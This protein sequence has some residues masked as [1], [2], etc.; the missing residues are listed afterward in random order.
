MAQ[1]R[2]TQKKRYKIKY[3]NVA[4]LLAIFLILILLI[5]KGCSAIF[6]GREKDDDNPNRDNPI[7]SG[8]V[9]QPDPVIPDDLGNT[10]PTN[11]RYYHFT[12]VSKTASDLGVG[13]L[14]LVN[15]NIAFNGLVSEDDLVVIRE[16]KNNAYSVKDYSVLILPQ[17]MDA[18]N[19]MLLGFREAT[20]NDHIMV[21]SGYRTP[22]YQQ[23]LY[24]EDLANTGSDSSSLVAKPGYSEHYTGLVV[25][26]TTDYYKQSDI[27]TGDY[28]WINENCHKYGFIN[29]YPAG[30]E[31]LTMIDNEPWHYRY[32]GIPHA[33]VMHDRDLCL[34]EYID[35]IKNF[36]I[37]T[38]FLSVTTDDGSQYIIYY[39]PQ[40]KSSENTAVYIPLTGGQ[41]S[42]PYPY[43]ISGNNVDGWIVTFLFK[44]GT[45]TQTVP[46]VGDP[47]AADAPEAPDEGDAE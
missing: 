35:Y 3:K 8:D 43:E 31:P 9:Q 40:N 10:D 4:L 5:A 13:D 7:G 44:E 15:N 41:G 28:L 45:G 24:D 1:R 37:N 2:Y 16:K 38:G 39:V 23:G 20:G 47:A 33:T 18:L 46:Q 12:S 25:D 6:S 17:A 27:G 14:V 36:T 11:Q 21:N 22:E 19:E 29:R 26:F 30:K 32:V 42:P 34:E